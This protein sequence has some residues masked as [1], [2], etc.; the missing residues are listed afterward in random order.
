MSAL[1]A[2]LDSPSVIG[3][4]LADGVTGLTYASGGA[5]E[6]AGDGVELAELAGLITGSLDAA[7]AGARL[8]SIVVTCTRHYQVIQP[9]P[10]TGPGDPVLLA[11][12]MDRGSTNLALAVR[13]AADV[14][15]ELLA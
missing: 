3:A 11:M 9:L 13:Q 15:G 6:A 1:E 14:A 2:A 4:V 12:V 8:E 10:E 5:Y 7:G